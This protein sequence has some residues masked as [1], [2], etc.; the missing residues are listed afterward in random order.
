NLALLRNDVRRRNSCAAEWALPM[1]PLADVHGAVDAALL[2]KFGHDCGVLIDR[3]HQYGDVLVFQALCE[4]LDA[5]QLRATGCAPGRP[6]ID[7]EHLACILFER[8][9]TPI[10]PENR[11]VE[12]DASITRIRHD[13]RR[14]RKLTL[15]EDGSRQNSG[16]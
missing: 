5:G 10:Q 3:D 1:A 11:K 2:E 8:R 7:E 16:N 15:T 6:E 12:I 9:Q 4:G 13:R 14:Q